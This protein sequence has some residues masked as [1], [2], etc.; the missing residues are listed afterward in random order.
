[1][2]DKNPPLSMRHISDEDLSRSADG[3]LSSPR[4]LEVEAHLEV[5]RDCR[6]RME[7]IQ[8]T[9]TDFARAHHAEFDQRLPPNAGSR[10]LLLARLGELSSEMQTPWWQ[11]AFPFP[12]RLR[13]VALACVALIAVAIGMAWLRHSS[14]RELKAGSEFFD[15]ETAP[16]RNLTPGVTRAVTM[17][18]V[19]AVPQEEV[20]EN[21][22][23]SLQQQVFRE[24]GITNARPEDYE[25]DYLIAPRLGG[26]E[27]IRN[28]WP[29]PY[30]ARVW[31]ARVKDSLEQRLH[32]MVCT[33]QLDLHTAQQD[34][35]T[36]WIA[37]YQKYF[38]TNKPLP[39]SL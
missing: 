34:I 7:E 12:L 14:R 39:R 17:S 38:H 26:T 2:L 30:R 4:T 6:A 22:S 13:H 21:V 23:T 20:V 31:N 36:D 24:Y 27:D 10:A 8:S 15:T 11:R 3:E 16:N 19:C 5:C 18:E 28:L 33:G 32:E 1:M 25:I 37:A 9:I 29:E 35:A